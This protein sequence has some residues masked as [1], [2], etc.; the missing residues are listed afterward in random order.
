MAYRAF[1]TD[2]ILQSVFEI[3][4][5]GRPCYINDDKFIVFTDGLPPFSD[6]LITE[7]ILKTR[8]D[9]PMKMLR[10]VRNQKLFD[11]DVYMIPD[12][13]ISAENRQ[14]IV[15]YRQTLRDLPEMLKDVEIDIGNLEQ[16]FPQIP[17]F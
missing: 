4:P 11:T 8:R 10:Y 5:S 13:P 17:S 3:T 14:A 6:E 9:K 15:S 16:Y 2:E 1:T 12:Y 7:T